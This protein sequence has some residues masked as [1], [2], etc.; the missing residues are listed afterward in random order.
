M[1]LSLS[2]G[3]WCVFAGICT[4]SRVGWIGTD[5]QPV[6][7]RTRQGPA[8]DKQPV[9]LRTGQGPLKFQNKALLMLW[10]IWLF[11]QPDKPQRMQCL[12]LRLEW[13]LS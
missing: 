11:K 1:C 8:T 2:C 6:G 4:K 3:V 13:S 12:V 5:K 9:G 7:L 10:F